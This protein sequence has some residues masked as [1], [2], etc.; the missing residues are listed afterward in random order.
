M[1]YAGGDEVNDPFATE[2]S[3]Q[4][5]PDDLS[6]SAA[7]ESAL[8]VETPSLAPSAASTSVAQSRWRRTKPPKGASPGDAPETD[9]TPTRKR[10]RIT[11]GADT[12]RMPALRL[13]RYVGRQH[14]EQKSAVVYD[15]EHAPAHLRLTRLVLGVALL[16]LAWGSSLIV[17]ALSEALWGAFPRHLSLTARFALYVLGAIGIVWLA[18][19][20]LALIVV[21][22]LSLSLA[23]TRREW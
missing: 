14:T 16:A 4:P 2:L 23:L 19:V 11:R 12:G 5:H 21:G 15:T 13:N 6:P 17:V 9:L 3:I 10:R 7:R 1:S 8:G 20:A 22:A 18:V